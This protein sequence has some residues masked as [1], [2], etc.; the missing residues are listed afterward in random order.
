MRTWAWLEDSCLLFGLEREKLRSSQSILLRLLP[1]LPPSLVM[2][3]ATNS[4]LAVD[5]AAF[6]RQQWVA[7]SLPPE[8][9]WIPCAELLVR[10]KTAMRIRYPLSVLALNRMV[11]EQCGWHSKTKRHLGKPALCWYVLA[12]D[13]PADYLPE[14][15]A[16]QRADNEARAAERTTAASAAESAEESAQE[17]ADE[18]AEESAEESAEKSA[19]ES[20][21]ESAAD[22]SDESAHAVSEDESDYDPVAHSSSDEEH[23]APAPVAASAA[24]VAVAPTACR[25]KSSLGL[26]CAE[27][28]VAESGTLQLCARHRRFQL[29]VEP[30]C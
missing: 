26:P 1:R 23:A 16:R 20:A 4:S 11:A 13:C 5:F 9:N 6:V 10:F 19:E 21:D 15:E 7:G 24:H 18:P 29:V 25:G 8:G 2:S 12:D 14:R 22:A 3:R 30:E 28:A 27:L 17:S